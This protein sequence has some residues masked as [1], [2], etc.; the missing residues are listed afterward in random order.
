MMYDEFQFES[1]NDTMESIPDQ[2]NLK[3]RVLTRN[4]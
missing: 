1:E 2:K 4:S 3:K